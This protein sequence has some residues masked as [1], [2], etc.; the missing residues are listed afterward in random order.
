MFHGNNYPWIFSR[1]EGTTEVSAYEP[2]PTQ[3]PL[4]GS[5]VERHV[6]T[7][8]GETH[9]DDQHQL[10]TRGRSVNEAHDP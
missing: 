10:D 5:L 4:R 2:T 8:T 1:L 9:E 6:V 7:T 3:G